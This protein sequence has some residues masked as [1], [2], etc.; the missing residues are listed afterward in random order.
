MCG[1]PLHF[2]FTK[3]DSQTE[4]HCCS[5][6]F[7][8]LTYRVAHELPLSLSVGFSSV[9]SI[10]RYFCIYE[11]GQTFLVL[12]SHIR[13]GGLDQI[14]PLIPDSQAFSTDNGHIIASPPD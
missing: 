13:A 10:Q 14:E 2:L 5:G 11:S 1:T 7:K 6:I 8:A 12:F 9:L 3:K 4:L